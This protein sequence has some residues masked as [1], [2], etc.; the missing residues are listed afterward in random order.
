ML[1]S[2]CSVFLIGLLSKKMKDNKW[3]FRDEYDIQSSLLSTFVLPFIPIPLGLSDFAD[4]L[5]W[6]PFVEGVGPVLP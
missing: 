4:P 6:T 1:E 3:W 2:I 5:L